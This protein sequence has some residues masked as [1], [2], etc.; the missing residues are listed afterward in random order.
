MF[1]HAGVLQFTDLY[2]R[3]FRG[4]GGSCEEG[5]PCFHGWSIYLLIW[6]RGYQLSADLGITIFKVRAS[7]FCGITFGSFA[8]YI[9]FSTCFR[10]WASDV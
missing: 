5:T 2:T 6:S 9:A 7:T 3:I 4:F 10:F 1:T 8:I